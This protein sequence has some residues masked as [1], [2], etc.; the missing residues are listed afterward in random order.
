MSQLSYR[1]AIDYLFGLEASKIKLGLDRTV[2]L[3]EAIGNPQQSFASVH[4]AGT[5]GKGSVASLVNSILYHNGLAVGLFTS[6]HLV[7]YRERIRRDGRSMPRQALCDIVSGLESHVRRIEA[8]YFEATTA[9]A[10]E[11]FKAA[12]VDV[13]VVEVGMGGRLDSTN[14]IRPLVTCITTIDFDHEKYLGRTLSEI[15]GEKAGIIKPGV[16]VVCGRMRGQALATIKAVARRRGARVYQV[17]R[18]ASVVPVASGLDGSTFEYVG[19][20]RRRR[21]KVGLVGSHQIENAAV[22][23][24]VAEVLKERGLKVG[25]RAIEQGLARALWPGRLQ[26]LRKRPL[27]IC[28]GAHNVSG[29]R[30][31]GRALGQ[32]GLGRTLTVFGVLRDKHYG[33]MLSALSGTSDRFIFTRPKWHRALPVKYLREAGGELG[34]DFRVASRV[35]PALSL[36]LAELGRME[37]AGA[38]HRAPQARQPRPPLLVCGSLYLVGEAMQFFGFQPH[39]IRLC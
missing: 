11:Y 16:P 4:I 9:V 13:A 38:S 36:A 18:D 30:A 39:R 31:L 21:L 12:G 14:V 37:P 3:L 25:D 6:P 22:A 19:L 29:T 10:F 27:V 17:G 23:V 24:L 34:L 2:N 26:V 33:R 5:N 35:A 32:L 20:G 15:A 7:D 28:D 1:A 8:S